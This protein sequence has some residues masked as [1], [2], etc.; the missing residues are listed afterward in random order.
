M[1]P[2]NPRELQPRRSMPS[3]PRVSGPPPSKSNE[4]PRAN[5]PCSHSGDPPSLRPPSATSPRL[6]N[7]DVAPTSTPP[8]TYPC[9][10]GGVGTA[11]GGEVG[12]SRSRASGVAPGCANA[13][14]TIVRIRIE[15]SRIMRSDLYKGRTTANPRTSRATRRADATSLSAA[16]E[17]SGGEDLPVQLG[18]A[19]SLRAVHRH[20]PAVVQ[21]DL[22]ER[23][24][25]AALR[26]TRP[27]E[28][29]RAFAAV[30]DERAAAAGSDLTDLRAVDPDVD[31]IGAPRVV[32]VERR[33]RL[34]AR[35]LLH[36]RRIRG[37]LLDH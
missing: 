36:G 17:F 4:S 21:V 22:A 12:S 2:Q 31:R 9:S 10:A 20:A 23:A 16:L 18:H 34:R 37:I 15:V 7:D 13:F 30:G 19:R 24:A 1:K 27:E 28:A 33:A 35:R 32:D 29:Q 3:I 11:A 26:G 5:T 25:I 8:P 6:M 14:P